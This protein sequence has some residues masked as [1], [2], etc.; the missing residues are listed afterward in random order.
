MLTA[1]QNFLETLKPDGKPDRLVNDYEF[2]KT[3][4]IDPLMRFTLA[5]LVHGHELGVAAQ[6]NVRT[7]ACHIGGDGDSAKFTGLGNDLCFLLMVLGV[8]HMVGNAGAL[9]QLT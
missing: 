6:H 3:V 9:E 4:M 5:Q 8:E 7:T 2:A 1:K